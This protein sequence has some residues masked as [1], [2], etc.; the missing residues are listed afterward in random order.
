MSSRAYKPTG[1]ADKSTAKSMLVCG[2]EN[3]K[4]TADFC[5]FVPGESHKLPGSYQ[6]TVNSGATNHPQ[7]RAFAV[8]LWPRNLLLICSSQEI[9]GFLRAQKINSKSLDLLLICSP[10]LLLICSSQAICGF[11][12]AHKS[13]ANPGPQIRC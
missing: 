5:W 9:C 13:T 10:N 6:S 11:L 2:H 3:D 12:R 8:D 1:Q 7:I 4:S